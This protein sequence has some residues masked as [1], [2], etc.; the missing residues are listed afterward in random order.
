MTKGGGI[1]SRLR[2]ISGLVLMTYVIGHL[3]NHAAGLISLSALE[4]TRELFGILWGAPGIR[5]LVPTSAVVHILVTS[6]FVLKRSSLRVK[7]GE[8]LRVILGALIPIILLGHI[9]SQRVMQDLHGLETTYTALFIGAPLYVALDGVL[10]VMVWVHGCLGIYYWLR[11]RPWFPAWSPYLYAAALLL[12][13]LA[14]LGVASGYQEAT[15]LATDPAFVAA[16]E[17]TYGMAFEVASDRTDAIAIPLI[18]A[19]VGA[20]ILALAIRAIVFGL[21]RRRAAVTVRYD[22]GDAVRVFKGMSVLE[23]SWSRRLPHAS[24][25]GGRGRC[26]TCR[27]RVISSSDALPPP[28]EDETRVLERIGAPPN[29]RL[30]CQLRPVSDL[31][32]APV[33]HRATA[34]DGFARPDYLDGSEREVVVLF[35][36]LRGF[37]RLSEKRLPYDVVFFLNQYFQLMGEC[38]DRY[39]GHLDKFIGD[40]TL[41]L[42]GIEQ[43]PQIGARQAL[44]AVREMAGRLHVLSDRLAPELG[45]PLRMGIGLH[46]GHAIVGRL[47]Y[48]SAMTLTAIGDAVNTASRLEG[49]SKELGCQLVLSE[50]VARH[51]GYGFDGY[52][53]REVALRGRSDSLK[54]IVVPTADEMTLVG[55]GSGEMAA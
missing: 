46:V 1:T 19:Y 51:A 49:M 5:W 22:T 24:V 42:F 54:V 52:E 48:K 11:L 9:V 37:T 14:L 7:W 15:R 35:A 23:A 43:G 55:A 31:M 17:G 26:S 8:L 6:W 44:V 40:G 4:R 38:I 27:V 30:A 50:D 2:L 29:V 20:L 47:G 45:A 41:A 13:V 10:L 53:R 25:C 36:D 18:A 32:V 33:L 34:A 3:S 39:G 12:P 28:T 21:R 16:A